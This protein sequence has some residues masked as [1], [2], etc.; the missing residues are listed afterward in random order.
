MEDL[1]Y[2]SDELARLSTLFKNQEFGST[3]LKGLGKFFN[4]KIWFISIK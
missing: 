4:L 1:S 2:L 3:N